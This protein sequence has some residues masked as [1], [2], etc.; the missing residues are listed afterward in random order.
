MKQAVRKSA[1]LLIAAGTLFLAGCGSSSTDKTVQT[2]SL[3]AASKEF[4]N[5]ELLVSADSLQASLTTGGLVIIDARSASA[6]GAGHIPGAINIQHSA[7]WTKGSGL[8]DSAVIAAQ[9]GAAGIARDKKIVV[10]DNTTASWG[11]AGR[12]FWMLEYLGCTDVH[13]L[14]GG[15]DKWAADTRP[16]QTIAVTL[17]AATFTPQT[18]SGVKVDAGHIAARL[19]DK[20]FAV[21]DART[22]EEYMG[23]QAVW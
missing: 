10:Y 1:F 6:Y 21:I 23:W 20:D 3:A 19:Y 14:N 16:V 4:P 9:L 8:K 7:Y 17:P 18:N 22:D 12:L 5:A 2:T 13:I 11:A 15:W